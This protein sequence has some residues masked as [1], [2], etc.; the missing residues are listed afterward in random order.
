MT[1][2][3]IVPA[4]D[5]GEDG[6]AGFGLGAETPSIE[7]FTFQGG[8]EALAHC[9]IIGVADRAHRRS[10]TGASA[11]GSEGQ[12]GV[13]AALVGMMN[14]AVWPALPNSHVQSVQDHLAAPR[15]A[16]AQPTMRRLKTSSTTARYRNP[17]HVGMYVMSATQS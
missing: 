12:R 9:I 11:A 1:P 3:R 8:K 5:E 14:D 4:L 10:H 17:D 16:R 15:G 7:Q 2:P 6:S 13:L